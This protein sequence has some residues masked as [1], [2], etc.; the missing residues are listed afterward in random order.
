VFVGMAMS[1]TL[2]ADFPRDIFEWFGTYR[3]DRYEVEGL[4]LMPMGGR[5]TAYWGADARAQSPT[6]DYIEILRRVD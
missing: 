4:V 6:E 1:W 5:S 2:R 3:R